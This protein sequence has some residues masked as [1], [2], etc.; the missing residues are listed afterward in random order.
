LTWPKPIRR[1]AD[2]FSRHISARRLALGLNDRFDG[3]V[4]S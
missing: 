3:S 4:Y 1:A 2:L